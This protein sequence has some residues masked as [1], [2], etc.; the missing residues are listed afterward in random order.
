MSIVTRLNLL[1]RLTALLL[2]LAV[3]LVLAWATLQVR[4]DAGVPA[5]ARTLPTSAVAAGD[6]QR[7]M[8]E[9]QAAAAP[10]AAPAPAVSQRYKLLGI[11]SG[12]RRAALMSQDGK[13]PRVWRPGDALADGYVVQH[14]GIREL[15]AAKAGDASATFRLELP[16]LPP[17]AT[18]VPGQTA[19][20]PGAP[21]MAPAPIMPPPRS[22]VMAPQGI[23]APGTE[24]QPMTAE[25][26]MQPGQVLGQMPGQPQPDNGRMGTGGMLLPTPQ[27]PGAAVIPEMAGGVEQPQ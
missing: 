6:W 8:G 5:D 24:P 15:V 16:L 23:Q 18:G 13:L 21:V 26:M 7:V 14:I 27:V 9:P 4:R 3:G 22:P 10:A 11:V 12:S 19:T 25:Q 17:P 2:W 1:P 20:A